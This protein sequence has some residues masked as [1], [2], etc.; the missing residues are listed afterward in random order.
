MD[1]IKSKIKH[2]K[3]DSTDKKIYEDVT[4]VKVK[5]DYKIYD[6]L[7]KLTSRKTNLISVPYKVEKKIFD[8]SIE[9]LAL[10]LFNSQSDYTKINGI[11]SELNKKLL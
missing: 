6:D 3:E 9:S 10:K 8:D 11:G 5:K 1:R 2:V 7:N 4:K